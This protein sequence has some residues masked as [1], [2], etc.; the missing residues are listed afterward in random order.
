M[1]TATLQMAM[2]A[3][4]AVASL[5][6]RGRGRQARAVLRENPM[7]WAFLAANKAEK[8]KLERRNDTQE[9]ALRSSKFGH[10]AIAVNDEAQ[11]LALTDNVVSLMRHDVEVELAPIN[12]FERGRGRHLRADRRWFQ[13]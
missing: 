6:P 5:W 2:S 10:E 1:L 13:V 11:V 3:R 8:A 4:L 7:E 12:L 9:L